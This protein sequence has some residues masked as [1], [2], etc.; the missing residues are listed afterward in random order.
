MGETDYDAL[1]GVELDSDAGAAD[2]AE[3]A[4]T[5]AEQGAQGAKE[6]DVAEPAVDG[7]G[8]EASAEDGAGQTPE[9][10]SRYAAARRKAEA[11][12]D[13]AVLKAREES[14]AE[15]KRQFEEKLAAAGLVNPYTKQPI[16]TMDDLTAFQNAQQQESKQRFM[17]AAGMNEEQY[18][19]F[20]DGLPEVK[21][22]REQQTAA[23]DAAKKVMVNEA[24]TKLDSQ[25][26]EITALNPEIRTVDDL[27]KMENYDQFYKLVKEN[28]LSLVDAYRLVNADKIAA[29]KTAATRQAAINAA[30]SKNHLD[31]TTT[32]GAG[33]VTVPKDEVEMY[34]A[35]NPGITDA[36]IQAHYSKYKQ[37][38]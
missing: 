36:E 8:A 1:F 7:E 26:A 20:V 27:K 5:G 13:A 33:A 29:E 17:K 4:G 10:N 37:R 25:M 32:R 24:R 3:D 35:L 18:K 6:Q 23:D 28:R 19:Q 11:E 21:A 16:R 12:R 34:R 2:T 30:N 31:R 38:K 15:T 14:A 9:E 22:A